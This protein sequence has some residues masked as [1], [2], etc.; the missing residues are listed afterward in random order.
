VRG[1]GGR[2]AGAVLPGQR[3]RLTLTSNDAGTAMLTFEHLP[4]GLASIQR[5]LASSVLRVPVLGGTLPRA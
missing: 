1:R 5:V 4:L 2:R 3:L